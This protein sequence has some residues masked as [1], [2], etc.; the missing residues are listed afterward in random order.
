M[1][2][3]ADWLEKLGMSEYTRRFAE[4][5]IDFAILS[6]LTDQDLEKLG[7]L[8]GDRRKL[9]GRTAP[10]VKVPVDGDDFLRDPLAAQR[11]HDVAH[12]EVIDDGLS[13][14][15]MICFDRRRLPRLSC[16][17]EER[18][19]LVSLIRYHT[20]LSG[21]KEQGVHLGSSKSTSQQGY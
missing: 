12:P 13:Y 11:R 3:T 10:A 20:V 4:K 9:L 14:L 2:Q 17:A 21:L 15:N 1:Q 18:P 8:L 6:D 19:G 16:N 7:V 5:D